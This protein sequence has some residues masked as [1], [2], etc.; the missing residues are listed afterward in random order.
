[1]RR[2]YRP[3]NR[4]VDEQA[5]PEPADAA[6]G[7]TKQ[8]L[9]DVVIEHRGQ[10]STKTF[11]TIRKTARVSGP[12]HGGRNHVFSPEDLFALIHVAE[13][14]R[15]TE[16][17]PEAAKAWRALLKDAGIKMPEVISRARRR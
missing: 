17:G 4:F 3:Q 6:P 1:M 12:S 10:L 2:A 8:E 14:G 9:L 7:W 13:G 11:D 15:F 5:A 16:R